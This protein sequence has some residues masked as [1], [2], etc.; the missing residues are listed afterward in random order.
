VSFKE[1]SLA[2]WTSF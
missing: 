2:K 1:T